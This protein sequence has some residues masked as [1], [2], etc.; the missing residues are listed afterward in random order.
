MEVAA[1]KPDAQHA[2]ERPGKLILQ[3]RRERRTNT[4]PTA[5]NAREEQ[6]KPVQ[7][8]QGERA[9]LKPFTA[10]D[11][12][13]YR[14]VY[15]ACCDFH[16]RHNPPRLDDSYWDEAAADLLET[17]Q[18]FSENDFALE[19]LATVYTELERQYKQMHSNSGE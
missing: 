16:E 2:Q 18:Q 12:S 14:K 6:Q 3:P 15:R 5:R 1:H 7:P 11:G 4:T 13:N 19:M 10:L 8:A 9:A 17:S